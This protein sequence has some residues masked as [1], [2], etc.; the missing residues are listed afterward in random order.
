MTKRMN[1]EEMESSPVRLPLPPLPQGH[2]V[3]HVGFLARDRQP[4][5]KANDEQKR[6]AREIGH[7]AD[8]WYSLACQGKA[9]IYQRRIGKERFE[10]VGK[11]CLKTLMG[12]E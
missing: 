6:V 10:Y 7:T 4:P 12:K 5:E 8:W 11:L 3:Y 1:V 2:E 9:V